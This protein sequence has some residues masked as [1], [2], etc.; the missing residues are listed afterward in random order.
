MFGEGRLG[1]VFLVLEG[2]LFVGVVKGN[3]KENQDF[4]T[5]EWGCGRGF[6]YRLVRGSTTWF[7]I[8]RL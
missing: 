5:T 3:Q 7:Y 1:C 8:V 6:Y 4:R 2:S